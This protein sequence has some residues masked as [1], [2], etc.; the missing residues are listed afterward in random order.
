MAGQP[1]HPR[2]LQGSLPTGPKWPLLLQGAAVHPPSNH[3]HQQPMGWST[4]SVELRAGKERELVAIFDGAQ[5]QKALQVEQSEASSVCF[6][7][8]P[9]C[10][11]S[12][13]HLDVWA[14][15]VF[16]SDTC[17]VCIRENWNMCA[18]FWDGLMD[19]H[20]DQQSIERWQLLDALFHI[21]KKCTSFISFT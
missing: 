10:Y 17:T 7:V 3:Q 2:G 9:A 6:L 20:V 8:P 5:K 11:Y 1:M 18:Y 15:Q 14:L 19:Q 16:Y 12:I 21:D 13:M 4:H